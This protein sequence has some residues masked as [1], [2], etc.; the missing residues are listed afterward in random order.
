VETFD[1][2]GH[3]HREVNRWALSHIEG[4]LGARVE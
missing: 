1:A 4:I 3:D 2:P